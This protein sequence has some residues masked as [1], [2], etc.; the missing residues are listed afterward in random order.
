M[1]KKYL[2]V[3][4][5]SKTMNNGMLDLQIV[6]NNKEE[7]EKRIKEIV[8]KLIIQGDKKEIIAY[9]DFELWKLAELNENYK[10]FEIKKEKLFDYKEI[11]EKTKIKILENLKNE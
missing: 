4:T 8:A 10:D 5:K 6:N 2:A 7:I 11:V 1:E 3:Y 9:S